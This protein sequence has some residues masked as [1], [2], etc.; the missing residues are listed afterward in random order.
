MINLGHL[1]VVGVGTRGNSSTIHERNEDGILVIS[2]PP[3]DNEYLNWKV[4]PFDLL[5]YTLEE[6]TIQHRNL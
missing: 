3:F 1:M 4:K 2:C 5:C 6:T